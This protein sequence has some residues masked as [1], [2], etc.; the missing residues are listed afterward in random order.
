[1]PQSVGAR[2]AQARREKAVREQRDITQRDMAKAVHVS[3]ASVSEWEADKAVPREDTL[4][5]LAAYLGTTPAQLRYGV[6]LDLGIAADPETSAEDTIRA[7]TPHTDKKATGGGR[8][9]HGK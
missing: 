1:M 5:R 6:A 7:L 8:S 4:A 3:S 2:I 9:R